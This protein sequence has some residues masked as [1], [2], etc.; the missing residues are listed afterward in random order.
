MDMILLDW[1]RMG[2]CYCVAGAVLEQGRWRIVRPLLCKRGYFPPR[3]AGW[4]PF[5]LD[6]YQRWECFELLGPTPAD[7]EPPHLEDCWVRSL[8]PYRRFAAPDLRR[9][10]LDATIVPAGEPLFGDP[11]SATRTAAYLAPGLGKRSLATVVVPAAQIRF[12]AGWRQG[13]LE[14]DMRVTLPLPL[15]GPRTLPVKD[16]HLLR[17]VEAL[18]RDL[19][20]RTAALT[21]LVRRMGEC[22]AVRLGLS[23]PFQAHG[24]APASCW[25]MADGFF[26]L[27]DPQP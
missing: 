27:V 3:G 12:G 15:L 11:L 4:S 14:P 24:S 7:P 5:Y 8:K 25:L 20:Q 19:N 10:I 9:A 22:V 13:Q 17:K 2:P 26:S 16:H 6:G 18:S 23:R 21:D 1:T